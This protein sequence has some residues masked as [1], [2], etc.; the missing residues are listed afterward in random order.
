MG[1]AGTIAVENRLAIKRLDEFNVQYERGA[2]HVAENGAVMR[3]TQK[4]A[5]F[6]MWNPHWSVMRQAGAEILALEAELG[7]APVGRGKA[8]KVQRANSVS[9]AHPDDPAG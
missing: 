5:K 3:S 9:Q 6:G 4:R 7:I 2:R 8:T 1:D